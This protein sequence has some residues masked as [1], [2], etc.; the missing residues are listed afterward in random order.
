[1]ILGAFWDGPQNR[2]M[3]YDLF[4]WAHIRNVFTS[5]KPIWQKGW[6]SLA[7][8]SILVPILY[9]SAIYNNNRR[10][11]LK[12]YAL[13]DCA[14]NSSFV[15]MWRHDPGWMLSRLKSYSK[16]K[17]S[18]TFILAYARIPLQAS[19]NQYSITLF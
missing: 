15:K 16:N 2:H 14:D 4:L 7:I 13:L 17:N 8:F 19:V 5:R 18:L 12:G 11:V 9:L 6:V 10:S 1:M 3:R